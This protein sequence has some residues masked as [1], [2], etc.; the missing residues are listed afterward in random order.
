[1][2]VV[3]PTSSIVGSVVGAARSA[4]L[5]TYALFEEG[6]D[7]SSILSVTA[8]APVPPVAEDEEGAIARTNDSVAYGGSAHVITDTDHEPPSIASTASEKYGE[9]FADAFADVSWQTDIPA[10]VL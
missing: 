1:Y 2:L 8:S 5:A 6:I 10:E 3:Y 9:P 4:E 7:P